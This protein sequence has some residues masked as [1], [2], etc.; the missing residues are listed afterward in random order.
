MPRRKKQSSE[1]AVRDIRRKTRRRFSATARSSLKPQ[2]ELTLENVALRQQ[3]AVLHRNIKR[4]KLTKVD[5][6]IWVALSRLWSDWQSALVVPPQN[7][8]D[9]AIVD[10][11]VL[12]VKLAYPVPPQNPVDCTIVDVSALGVA[13]AYPDAS[14]AVP[15]A[16]NRQIE[17]EA[18][19]R[20]RCASSEPRGPHNR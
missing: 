15:P 7:P 1:A 5:R 10:V 4:P 19:A 13:L 12:G 16:R 9:G 3:L 18:A 8:V 11:S 14:L 2:R 20:T 6:A 17:P